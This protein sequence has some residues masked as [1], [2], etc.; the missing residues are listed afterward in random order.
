MLVSV[1]Q[2][3][4]RQAVEVVSGLILFVVGR[5]ASE[6][7]IVVLFG[8][9]VVALPFVAIGVAI[10]KGVE[11]LFEGGCYSTEPPSPLGDQNSSRFAS[12]S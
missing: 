8:M 6:S 4:I 11:G 7:S 3:R 12:G 9:L 2:V 10:T 1:R 5:A